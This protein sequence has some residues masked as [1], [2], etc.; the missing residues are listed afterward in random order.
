MALIAMAGLPGAGKSTVADGLGR[1]LRAPVIS[2]DPIE[3]AIWRAGVPSTQPTGLAAYFVA[4]TIARTNLDLGL[5]VIIDA[6]NAVEAARWTWRDMAASTGEPLRFVEVVCSDKE[7]HRARLEARTRKIEGF[8]V[9]PWETVLA[10]SAEWTSWSDER[11][12][13]DSLDPIEDNL[14]RALDY[15]RG[16]S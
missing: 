2:V 9:T 4:E 15:V 7:I 13:L 8:E 5:T 14:R 3:S 16:C 1:A 6:V 12:T 10:A 11:L